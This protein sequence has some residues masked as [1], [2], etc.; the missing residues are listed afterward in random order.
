M[1]LKGPR[2]GVSITA[3]SATTLV[4]LFAVRLAPESSPAAR[5]ADLA[6]MQNCID[7]HGRAD[8]GGIVD[9]KLDCLARPAENVDAHYRGACQDYLAYFEMVR[10][11]RN[12]A[13][14]ISA[15]NPNRLLKGEGLARDYGCFQCHGDLGQGGS[16]NHRALKGYI[17]GYFGDDFV[18]LTR[19]GSAESIMA[20]IRHGADPALVDSGVRGYIARFFLERQAVK[21]PQ[22]RTLP[23]NEIRLL[24]EYLIAL[25]QYGEMDASDIRDYGRR[26]VSRTSI[27]VAGHHSQE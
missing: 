20:W 15:G 12:F 23:E 24:V 14:R 21:M 5:G 25:H 7:C 6:Y 19:G 11:K 17:P 27:T 3:I 1:L 2:I 16:R 8:T 26:T 13:L 18:A 10:L 22:F 4:A 9:E